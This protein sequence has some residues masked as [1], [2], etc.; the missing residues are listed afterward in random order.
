MAIKYCIKQT[1]PEFWTL[2][3]WRPGPF[4]GSWVDI[5][6]FSVERTAVDA[7]MRLVRSSEWVSPHPKFYDEY[8]EQSVDF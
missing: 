8:G 6:T 5:E 2:S 3:K 7:M 4:G 1:T